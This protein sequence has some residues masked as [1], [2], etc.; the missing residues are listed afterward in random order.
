[1]LCA[2]MSLR[3][4]F[5]KYSPA[6]C[7]LPLNDSCNEFFLRALQILMSLMSYVP[8]A[9]YKNIAQGNNCPNELPNKHFYFKYF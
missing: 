8:L 7:F 9:T 5:L 6:L 3:S 4:V 1:M 2:F